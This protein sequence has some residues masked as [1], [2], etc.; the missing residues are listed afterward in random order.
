M[1]AV[2]ISIVRLFQNILYNVGF[3]YAILNFLLPSKNSKTL[4]H[5]ANVTENNT[6]MM[7]RLWLLQGMNLSKHNCVLLSYMSSSLPLHTDN[8][9]LLGKQQVMQCIIVKRYGYAV[10]PLFINHQVIRSMHHYCTIRYA[11]YAAFK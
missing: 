11:Q 7:S 3:P 6:E 2:I 4:Y 8:Q 10:S 5:F 1:K 9:N